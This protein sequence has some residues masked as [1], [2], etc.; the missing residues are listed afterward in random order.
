MIRGLRASDLDEV[1][2]LHLRAFRGSI[3]AVLGHRYA[4]AFLSWFLDQPDSIC[5]VFDFAGETAGY[6]FG[7]PD[8]YGHDLARDLRPTV[9]LAALTHPQIILHRHFAAKARGRLRGLLGKLRRRG[10]AASA[11]APRSQDTFALTGIGVSPRHRKRKIGQQ[12]CTAF[13][14]RAAAA[15]FRRVTLDVYT[16]NVAARR[17]YE[18]LGWSVAE[19]HGTFL[20][21]EKLLTP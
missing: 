12:L 2:E 14:Q 3:G 19:D 11:P 21:Y 5:L 16:D 18:S 13:E 6:V 8:G 1:A 4:R 17:L 15:G 20:L 7:A 10:Q 9:V